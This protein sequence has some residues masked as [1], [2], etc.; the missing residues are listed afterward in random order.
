MKIIGRILIILLAVAIVSGATVL[1][2]NATGYGSRPN[3]TGRE[4]GFDRPEFVPGDRPEGFEG[5]FRP[6]R[7]EREGGRFGLNRSLMLL[8]PL[9]IIVVLFLGIERLFDSL[10]RR[11]LAKAKA[12]NE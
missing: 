4:V 8:I 9:T 3:L 6:E 11:R 1:I 10:R 2:V 12:Q 7:D 5:S